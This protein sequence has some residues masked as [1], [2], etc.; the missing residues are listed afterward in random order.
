MVTKKRNKEAKCTNLFNRHV[1]FF[2]HE[3]NDG[4][5]DKTSKEACTTANKANNNGI[6]EMRDL[7]KKM[8]EIQIKYSYLALRIIVMVYF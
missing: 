1:G 6:P 7:K 3:T 2:G 5:D 4:I 8:N